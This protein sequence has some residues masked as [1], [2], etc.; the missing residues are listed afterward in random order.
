MPPLVQLAVWVTPLSA[1][2]TGSP[3][4][5]CGVWSSM[6]TP[7]L[8]AEPGPGTGIGVMPPMG[9]GCGANAHGGPMRKSGPDVPV[10]GLGR[11]VPNGAL[12][13]PAGGQSH[14]QVH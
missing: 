1:Q 14:E 11:N 2:V 7:W 3:I 4:T 8:T 12:T 13:G 6:T 5:K 10:S 9:T